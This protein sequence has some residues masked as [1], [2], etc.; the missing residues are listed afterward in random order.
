MCGAHSRATLPDSFS[1]ALVTYVMA[2]DLHSKQNLLAVYN[3]LPG[4]NAAELKT[5]V[6]G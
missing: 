2:G 5:V 4:I 3:Q 1:T 6:E